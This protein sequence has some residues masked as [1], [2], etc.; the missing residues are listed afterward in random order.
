MRFKSLTGKD[1]QTGDIGRIG[2]LISLV[3]YNFFCGLVVLSSLKF[4][5]I[6]YG[7]GLGLLTSAFGLFI[8]AK[9]DTEPE[10][11]VKDANLGS[12]K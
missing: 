12:N 3:C 5:M 6:N 10:P 2:F 1:N 11:E 8:Y 7:T 9:K 4:E